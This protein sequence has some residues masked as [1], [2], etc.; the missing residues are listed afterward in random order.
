M[1][2]GGQLKATTWSYAVLPERASSSRKPLPVVLTASM[3]SRISGVAATVFAPAV[4]AM[5]KR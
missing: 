5:R 3:W 2:I 4:A 1:V